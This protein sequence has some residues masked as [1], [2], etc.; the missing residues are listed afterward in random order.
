MSVMH[1]EQMFS[2]DSCSNSQH[3]TLKSVPE[4]LISVTTKTEEIILCYDYVTSTVLWQWDIIYDYLF[5]LCMLD[6]TAHLNLTA[7]YSPIASNDR[8]IKH[9]WKGCERKRT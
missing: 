7:R 8:I 9:K 4:L 2:K 3:V 1:S 5:I 6:I